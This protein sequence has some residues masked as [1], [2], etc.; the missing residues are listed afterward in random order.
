ML[1]SS[2]KTMVSALSPSRIHES[3]KPYIIYGTAWKKGETSRFVSEAVH[4]GFRFIDTA[5]QPKHYNEAG[6]GDGWVSAAKDLGLNREDFSIQTKFTSVD[7]QDINNVPYDLEASIEDQV[8]QSLDVSLRNLKTDYI[9]SLVMHS[10]FRKMSDTIKAWRVFE[11]FVDEGKV[12]QLGI[13]NCYDIN[14]FKNL[15]NEARI[16]PSVLQN[17]FYSDSNFDTELR[18]FCHDNGGILYQ[19][20]WTLTAHSNRRALQMPEVKQIA[21]AKDLTPSTL[22]YAFMLTLGHTPLSGTTDRLHMAE[23]VAVMERIIGGETILNQEDINIIST[24][25]GI[26]NF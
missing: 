14:V 12:R 17:R 24:A 4:A 23:N 25:L 19:S 18:Q 6:V 20:F 11:S 21:A 2:S 15:Y 13:S 3:G 1:R 5:C 8:R 9:D 26:P 7:G 10:P 22:M 16:K